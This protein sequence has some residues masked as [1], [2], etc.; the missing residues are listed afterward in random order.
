MNSKK[1]QKR[2]QLISPKK[3]I[4]F[5]IFAILIPIIF[6]LLLELFLRIINFGLNNELLIESKLNPGY[7]QIN[8]AL[9][10][11]YF[12]ASQIQPEVSN[13]FILADKP[14]TTYR[15]FILGGSS[16]AGYPYGYN[17]SFST[18][19]RLLL[20][21][22]FPKQHFE[23][24][25]LAMPAVNSY[26]MSDLLNQLWKYDPDLILIYSGHNEFYGAL[27]VGS[28]EY[29]GTSKSFIK[30]Y[31]KISQFRV[32]QLIHKFINLVHP[33]S[34]DFSQDKG[35]LMERIVDKKEIKY[36]SPLYWKAIN[37]YRDNLLD[38]YQSCKEHHTPII[39]STLVSNIYDQRPFIDL[40]ATPATEDQ[41][42]Q[43]QMLSRKTFT[44]ND[45]ITSINNLRKYIK[46]DSIPATPYFILASIQEM[47]G[48]TIASYNNFYQAKDN[49]ALRFRASEDFNHIIWKLHQEFQIP[50]ADVK[51]IFESES[52]HQIPGENLL[53]DHL[54]PNLDGY[55]LMAK[56]FYYKIVEL[57]LFKHVGN[58]LIPDKLIR[59]KFGLTTLDEEIG[60]LRILILKNGWPFKKGKIG[61]IN[62]LKYHP[63]TAVQQFALNYWKKEI[64]WEKA[65][66]ELAE[67]YEKNQ[68]WDLAENEYRALI[69]GTPMNPSP[70][71]RL[72]ILLINQN[73]LEEVI[74]ILKKLIKLENNFF[75]YKM[76][77]AIYI[78]NNLI[79][80]GLIYLEHAYQLK[81]NDPQNL[82]NLSGVYLL[83]NQPDKAKIIAEKLGQIDPN[84]PG[85]QKLWKQIEKLNN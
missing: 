19:L 82:Y 29:L 33:L 73:K 52:K 75:G 58:S 12:P 11:K 40:F 16:A 60:N 66:V 25:N 69:V 9:G 1:N 7:L 37:N 68:K 48:D 81:E 83:V 28:M 42:H 22:N 13:D 59:Q 4:I 23:V 79:K 34:S 64:S 26:T 5:H 39:L 62:E 50:I 61:Q 84:F 41:W 14:D 51:S 10:Q 54:H 71:Q 20:E 74:P 78:K 46:E 47:M 56:A 72:A 21:N 44:E 17:G 36:H 2:E 70:Y 67:Y 65:H 45:L 63:H 18:M 30:F 53:L 57:N 6:F 80:K 55:Y 77:G 35:T 32:F 85:F 8:L 49:D 31:L 3:K 38:I 24:M 15:I 43:V 27:G 76:L